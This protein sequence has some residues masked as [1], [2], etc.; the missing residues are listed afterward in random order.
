MTRTDYSNGVIRL[1]ADEG[2]TLTDGQSYSKN[3]LIGLHGNVNAWIE[4][5]DEEAMKRQLEQNEPELTNEKL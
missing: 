2:F 1:I 3:L 4:I 5:L